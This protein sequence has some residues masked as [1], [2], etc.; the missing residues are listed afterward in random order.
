[1]HALRIFHHLKI[2]GEIFLLLWL[3]DN[4]QNKGKKERKLE[5]KKQ[6]EANI[7][8]EVTDG[9]IVNLEIRNSDD[10]LSVGTALNFAKDI[11]DSTWYD[12]AVFISVLT[13]NHRISLEG[14]REREKR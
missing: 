9:F 5:Q 10:K 11:R 7:R 1:V 8:N 4:L 13:A 6:K 12:A 2:T 14:A 3:R